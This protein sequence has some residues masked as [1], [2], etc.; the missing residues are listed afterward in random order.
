[1]ISLAGRD[2]TLNNASRDNSL[3][4]L[5]TVRNVITDR[6]HSSKLAIRLEQNYMDATP[7]HNVI[8]TEFKSSQYNSR[9]PNTG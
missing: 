2:A 8:P 7:M 6:K 4:S 9:Q 1:M 3:D 5:R